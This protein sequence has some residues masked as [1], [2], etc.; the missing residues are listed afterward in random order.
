M[1]IVSGTEIGGNTIIK[2]SEG[3]TV[4]RVKSFDT[5]T[6]LAEIYGFVT[7]IGD[8]SEIIDRIYGVGSIFSKDGGSK[9]DQIPTFK[10]ILYDCKAYDKKT[11]KELK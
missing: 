5:D 6:K 11:G 8:D 3:Y 1:I 2:N 10:C 4:K 7:L 9:E